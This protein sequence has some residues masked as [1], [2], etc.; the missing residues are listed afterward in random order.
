MNAVIATD[1]LIPVCGCRCSTGVHGAVRTAFV[2]G[3]LGKEGEHPGRYSTTA[4]AGK[5]MSVLFVLFFTVRTRSMRSQRCQ[6][7]SC[8]VPVRMFFWYM[9]ESLLSV[10]FHFF[11]VS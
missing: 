4:G 11:F 1:A 9:E 7:V 10:K 5:N 6:Q 2:A 3:R 8:G